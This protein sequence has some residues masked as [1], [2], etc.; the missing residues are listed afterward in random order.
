MDC[1]RRPS[2]RSDNGHPRCRA[3]K[4][5]RSSEIRHL[6]L[7]TAAYERPG[8]NYASVSAPKG[9]NEFFAFSNN[10]EEEFHSGEIC[11]GCSMLRPGPG[12]SSSEKNQKKVQDSA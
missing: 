1:P 12:D 2:W 9:C 5:C 4:G 7:D 3:N 10:N 6:I 8:A 11:L